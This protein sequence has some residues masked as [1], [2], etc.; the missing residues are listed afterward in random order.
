MLSRI[1][2][3]TLILTVLVG[4]S[5]SVS[6]DDARKKAG[7]GIKAYTP[8][9]LTWAQVPEAPEGLM[10][11]VVWGDPDKGAYGAYTKFPAGMKIPLHYHT[12]SSKNLFV[13][14]TLVVTA[15][16]GKRYEF[17]PGAFAEVRADWKHT[18]EVGPEGAVIFEWSTEKSGVM[19]VEAKQ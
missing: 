10:M 15:E 2:G 3:I 19:M 5:L 7:A 6:A 14:G 11:A 8:D 16:D 18:T 4:L 12:N 9:K 1:I 13:S 17:G